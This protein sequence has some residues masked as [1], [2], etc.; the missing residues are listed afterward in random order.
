MTPADARLLA[1]TKRS[2]ALAIRARRI[3]ERI[4]ELCE[5]SVG[6][7]WRERLMIESEIAELKAKADRY[8]TE[9]K[10]GLSVVH[11]AQSSRAAKLSAS[12][13]SHT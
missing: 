3:S 10:A 6:A 9:A 13:W 7:A 4:S 12:R 1:E 2:D 8:E 5:A 11:G